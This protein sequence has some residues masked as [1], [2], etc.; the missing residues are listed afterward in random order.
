MSLEEFEE[1]QE[2]LESQSADALID[3]ILL[4]EK[5]AQALGVQESTP[6]DFDGD[7]QDLADRAALKRVPG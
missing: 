7:Q 3:R 2:G 6:N 1:D 5:R 4:R